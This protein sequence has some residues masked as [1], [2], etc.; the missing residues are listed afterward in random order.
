MSREIDGKKWIQVE[1]VNYDLSEHRHRQTTVTKGRN[2]VC[3]IFALL[4]Y[5]MFLLSEA[6]MNSSVGFVCHNLGM[7][8]EQ[9]CRPFAS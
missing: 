4:N 2:S 5:L 3:I 7:P 9:N 6:C 1:M 8:P